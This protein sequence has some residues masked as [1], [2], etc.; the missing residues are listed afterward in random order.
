MNTKKILSKEIHTAFYKEY[1][2][3]I[4]IFQEIDNLFLG[5]NVLS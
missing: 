3:I 2:R 5:Y 4:S 1:C